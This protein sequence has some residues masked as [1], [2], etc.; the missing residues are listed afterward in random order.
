MTEL[1]F[2]EKYESAVACKFWLTI[3]SDSLTDKGKEELAKLS[4]YIESN[5]DKYYTVTGK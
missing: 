3:L 2:C 5:K 1:D 4:E